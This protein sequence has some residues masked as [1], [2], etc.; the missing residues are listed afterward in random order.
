MGCTFCQTG[1]MGLLRNLSA[2]EIVSQVF[3]ARHTYGKFIRNIVFMGMGEPMDNFDEVKSAIAVLSCS[4]GL[5]IAPSRIT[6]STS[7]VISGI[8]RMIDEIDPAINL[9]VSVN[10]PNN[11]IRRKIMPV[12]Q[13]WNMDQLKIAM[14][15]YCANP[16]R[17]ILAEYVLLEGI[18]DSL[19][20]AN[21]LA[22]YLDGL[23]IKI[24]LIPY[25]SQERDRF[26]PPHSQVVDEFASRLRSLGYKTLVRTTK[27]SNIMAACGQLGNKEQRTRLHV[28]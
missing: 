5:Q 1:K 27:G 6:I 12:N 3:F 16:R 20:D 18:N 13:K 23:S 4:S 17:A 14:A 26:K 28:V 2:Q 25:N 15:D 21:Q 8:Y 11:D 10:A 7:G 22:T 24:N 19:A 9:A